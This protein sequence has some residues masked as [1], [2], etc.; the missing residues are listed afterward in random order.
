M[1]WQLLRVSSPSE[2]SGY[3][4]AL[5]VPRAGCT[6]SCRLPLTGTASS[7]ASCRIRI[8]DL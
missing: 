1:V 2:A 5:L 3:V 8:D 4:Q 6:W 7:T